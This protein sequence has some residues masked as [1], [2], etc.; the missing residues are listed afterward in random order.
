MLFIV[1]G[2]LFNTLY[3]TDGAKSLVLVFCTCAA[4]DK[5]NFFQGAFL[6]KPG[7]ARV[8]VHVLYRREE[9]SQSSVLRVC[10]ASS[11]WMRERGQRRA[12]FRDTL[13]KN[14]RRELLAVANAF[15]SLNVEIDTILRFKSFPD[16][17]IVMGCET[18]RQ[19]HNIF[20]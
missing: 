18:I 2:H 14:L 6:R 19:V 16:I 9:W 3:T 17:Y 20:T 5:L 7:R 13:G 12:A 8:S 15:N 10:G 1:T 11:T 4:E